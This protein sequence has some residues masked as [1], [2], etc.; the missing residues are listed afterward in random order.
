MVIRSRL[1]SGAWVDMREG[2]EGGLKGDQ[3]A[4]PRGVSK[5]KPVISAPKPTV[6]QGHT[7]LETS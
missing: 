7:I 5:D 6:T 4:R 2:D 1:L 3:D